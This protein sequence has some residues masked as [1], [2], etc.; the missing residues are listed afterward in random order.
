[1][2]LVCAMVFVYLAVFFIQ[3]LGCILIIGYLATV[4]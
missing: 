3:N 4:C 1:M 2:V